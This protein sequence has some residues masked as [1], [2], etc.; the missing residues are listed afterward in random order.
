[1]KSYLLI[2]TIILFGFALAE[3]NITTVEDC[4]VCA[5]SKQRVCRDS[6]TGDRF[7]CA[8]GEKGPNCGDK[9]QTIS[10]DDLNPDQSDGSNYLL[11]PNPA[12]CPDTIYLSS[13]PSGMRE[14]LLRNLP[15]CN[16]HITYYKGDQN[17]MKILA[18]MT[19]EVGVS[20]FRRM[21]ASRYERIGELQPMEILIE[22]DESIIL[23]AQRKMCYWCC[24]Y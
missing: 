18:T 13:S 17:A 19:S 16:T 1:M 6:Y 3:T 24:S 4:A 21:N 10:T 5:G 23:A 11:R 7:Y 15:Y 8:Q 2:L 9:A 12:E 20:A 22:E 14:I